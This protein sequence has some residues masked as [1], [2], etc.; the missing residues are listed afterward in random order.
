MYAPARSEQELQALSEFGFS[1]SDFERSVEVWPE[2]LR[3]VNLFSSLSTQWR[4]G[5]SGATG[6]DY[7]VLYHKLDRLQLSRQDYDWLEEDVQTLEAAALAAM[8]H[9]RD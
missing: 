8:N 1:G 9:K 2:N 5:M 6:L 4:V 3:A 7:N